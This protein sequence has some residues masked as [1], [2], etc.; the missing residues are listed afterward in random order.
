MYLVV[1]TGLDPDAGKI[2]AGLDSVSKS[3]ESG[4]ALDD[5]LKILLEAEIIDDEVTAKLL[6]QGNGQQVEIFREGD[7]L[8]L[9]DR[10]NPNRQGV[11]VQPGYF[12][13][14]GETS[15]NEPFESDSTDPPVKAK[16]K[17]S[18]WPVLLVSVALTAVVQVF[19][20]RQSAPALVA[21]APPSEVTEPVLN[22]WIES[23]QGFYLVDFDVDSLAL[24]LQPDRTY[25]LFRKTGPQENWEQLESGTITGVRSRNT[26]GFLLN[27]DL[28]LA[29][30]G[31][32]QLDY[33]GFLMN[34][35]TIPPGLKDELPTLP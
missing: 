30:T 16:S 24:L 13:G 27:G 33:Y 4:D 17:S 10:N 12:H 20:L 35:S 34:R 29:M 22:S 6:I 31:Q 9:N 15:A 5:I 7:G 25:H 3:I 2:R 18:L 14:D 26:T 21:S 1:M 32:N 23:W 19:L 8:I 28:Y 11:P